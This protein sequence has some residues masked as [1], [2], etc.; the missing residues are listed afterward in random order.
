MKKVNGMLTSAVMVA[1]YGPSAGGITASR[2]LDMA[3]TIPV[4]ERMPVNTPAAKI[5][6]TTARMFSACAPMRFF[7]SWM[8][9]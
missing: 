1:R 7:C 8:H 5:S 6:E 2:L 4:P 9:G 3:S